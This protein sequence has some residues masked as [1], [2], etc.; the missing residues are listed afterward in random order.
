MQCK[1]NIF[2]VSVIIPFSLPGA[3]PTA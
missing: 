3:G 2:V 1:Y